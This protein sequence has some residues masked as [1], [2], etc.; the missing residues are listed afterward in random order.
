[1]DLKRQLFLDLRHGNGSYSVVIPPSFQAVFA[2]DSVST[3]SNFVELAL[4]SHEF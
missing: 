1:M 3:Q 4:F 2:I